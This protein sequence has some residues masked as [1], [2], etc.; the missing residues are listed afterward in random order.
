MRPLISLLLFASLVF[1]SNPR[2]KFSNG[3][4]EDVV[5]TI[6]PDI[7]GDDANRIIEGIQS[8]I[9]DGSQQ[10][11][12]ATK[13][14]AYIRNVTILIPEHW[15][16][17]EAEDTAEVIHDEGD[18]AVG[19]TNPIYQGLPSTVQPGGCGDWGERIDVPV[20]FVK[21]PGIVQAPGLV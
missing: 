1:A 13:N 8:W 12:K 7:P 15:A 21:Y 16:V 2:V 5:V 19:L 9:G 20:S 17:D 6:S 10:L 18:I 3:G 14:M 11:F 4:Y